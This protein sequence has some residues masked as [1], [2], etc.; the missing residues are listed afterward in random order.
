MMRKLTCRCGSVLEVF[1]TTPYTQKWLLEHVE[2]G[3]L[4]SERLSK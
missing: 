2:H 1:Q 4:K 3:N